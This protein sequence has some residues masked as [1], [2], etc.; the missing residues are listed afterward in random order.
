MGGGDVLFR[1]RGGQWAR[2]LCSL[3]R[4]S[5]CS[6]SFVWVTVGGNLGNRGTNET[7]RKQRKSVFRKCFR[8]RGG[9]GEVVE[10][11]GGRTLVSN[12]AS[13][14]TC[15]RQILW[16]SVHHPASLRMCKGFR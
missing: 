14:P 5:V 4:D 3:R 11:K 8:H 2:G 15:K 12:G 16:I 13:D 10:G 6:T 1:E 9:R 7:P